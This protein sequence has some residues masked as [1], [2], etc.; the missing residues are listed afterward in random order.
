[1]SKTV[2]SKTR[3]AIEGWFTQDDRPAL[4]GSQC[5][6]CKSFFF[7]KEKFYCKNPECTGRNFE[8]VR[9]SSKGRIWSFTTNHFQPPAPYISP[10]PFKPYTIAA[11]ELEKEKMVVLGQMAEGFS[12]NNLSAGMEVEVV[13]ES[14][15][16]EDETDV[17]TWKWKPTEANQ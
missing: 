17:I 5:T 16:T 12:S 13:L 15:Y 1:M 6:Q 3:P 4:L 9:L 11:V 10:E 14:L 2:T 8:E 7:P